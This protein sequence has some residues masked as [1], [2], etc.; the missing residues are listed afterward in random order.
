M[1]DYGQ[2]PNEVVAAKP[3]DCLHTE[4]NFLDFFFHWR[5]LEM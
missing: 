5:E 1:A 2:E 3:E 4:G